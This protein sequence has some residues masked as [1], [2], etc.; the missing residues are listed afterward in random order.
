MLDSY[1]ISRFQELKLCGQRHGIAQEE[2]QRLDG[3]CIDYLQSLLQSGVLTEAEDMGFCYWN[4]SDNHALM[5]ESSALYENHKA[6]YEYLKPMDSKYLYWLVCDGTQRYVLENGGYSDFWWNIY[7]EA[8]ERNTDIAAYEGIVFEA[9]RA[10]F[11]PNPCRTDFASQTYAEEAFAA[12]LQDRKGSE[13][14]PFYYLIYQS[15]YLHVFGSCGD[16][17]AVLCSGFYE[18]LEIPRKPM[19]TVCGEWRNFLTENNDICR[20]ARVGI[21]AAVNSLIYTNQ[22]KKAGEIYFCARAHGLPQNRYI[23]KRIAGM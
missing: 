3:L 12:F 2:K 11:H 17:L 19:D 8:N 21:C 5:R 10:A 16:N 7:R 23:E 15:L 13:N 9:H 4:L 1:I 22:C 20:Q 14:Y 6:F 18:K